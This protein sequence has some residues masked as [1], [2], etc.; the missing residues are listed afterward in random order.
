MK[1]DNYKIRFYPNSNIGMGLQRHELAIGF[2]N[3]LNN[4]WKPQIFFV[5]SDSK[6]PDSKVTTLYGTGHLRLFL[7]IEFKE[8][9]GEEFPPFSAI[10]KYYKDHPRAETI[11][12]FR[13][14]G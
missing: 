4:D 6:N 14:R 8:I 2:A 1:E 12:N 9:F 3:K 13:F 5:P 7:K 10:A 11:K